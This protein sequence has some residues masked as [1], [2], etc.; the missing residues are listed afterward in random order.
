MDKKKNWLQIIIPK[1]TNLI[2]ASMYDITIIVNV[3]CSPYYTIT[4]ILV[5]IWM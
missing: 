3:D 1:N 5:Q 2:R 4:V